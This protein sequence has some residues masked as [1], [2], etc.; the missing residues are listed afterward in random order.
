[1]SAPRLNLLV[2]RSSDPKRLAAFYAALGLEFEQHRHGNGPM[3]FSAEA[4]PV[5]FEVYPFQTGE[6]D[7]SSTRIGFA[8]ADVDSAAERLVAAGATLMSSPRDSAWGRRAVLTDIDG[9]R[10]ELTSAMAERGITSR[11]E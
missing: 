9:H 1:M 5:T 3:H 4:G 11:N 7:M 6:T 10:L 8:V 2:L